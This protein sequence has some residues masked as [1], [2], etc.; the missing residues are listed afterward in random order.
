[1][2][3]QNQLNEEGD[4]WP[5]MCIRTCIDMCILLLHVPNSEQKMVKFYLGIYMCQFA[6][7]DELQNTLSILRGTT[8]LHGE[9]KG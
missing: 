1:M 7:I 8:T 6:K 2:W 3:L 9:N 4:F 5:S